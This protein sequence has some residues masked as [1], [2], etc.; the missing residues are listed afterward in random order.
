MLLQVESQ[1]GIPAKSSSLQKWHSICP[2][3]STT[4]D[5]V[6]LLLQ[7]LGCRIWRI[8][9]LAFLFKMHGKCICPLFTTTA[10]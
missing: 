9:W 2:S 1:A 6:H 3:N 7:Q 5:F 10:P 4:T 8:L